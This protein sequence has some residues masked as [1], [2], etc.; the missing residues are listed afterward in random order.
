MSRS[1]GWYFVMLCQILAKLARKVSFFIIKIIYLKCPFVEL[2]MI[3]KL[4]NNLCQ[5]FYTR[6]FNKSQK[7][8][9]QS[10]HTCAN[11]FNCLWTLAWLL[12]PAHLSL[13]FGGISTLQIKHNSEKN[14]HFSVTAAVSS[15]NCKTLNRTSIEISWTFILAHECSNVLGS[16]MPYCFNGFYS[17]FSIL[18]VLVI[19]LRA[20]YNFHNIKL[21]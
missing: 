2:K 4:S 10:V 12:S 8:Q 21:I 9:H 11:N 6:N 19:D 18:G 17:S 5:Q 13:T 15:E 20:E 14:S 3:M 7:H 16:Y 1:N